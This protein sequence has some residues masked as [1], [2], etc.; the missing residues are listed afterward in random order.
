MDEDSE[1]ILNRLNATSQSIKLSEGER[2]LKRDAKLER[3]EIGNKERFK[4]KKNSLRKGAFFMSNKTPDLLV[5]IQ[6]QIDFYF[7]D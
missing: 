1:F 5:Q 3:K 2:Q 6:R 4:A 7:S